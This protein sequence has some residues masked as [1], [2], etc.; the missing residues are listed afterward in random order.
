MCGSSD[1]HEDL[2]PRMLRVRARIAAGGL[3]VLRESAQSG[4]HHATMAELPHV[5]PGTHSDAQGRRD[6]LPDP[7]AGVAVEMEDGDHGVRT[8]VLLRG[9]AGG[10]P[11]CLL[12]SPAR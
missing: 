6:R 5:V 7:L 11:L 8:A 9:R 10:G 12:A 1:R 4:A 3:R 2:P